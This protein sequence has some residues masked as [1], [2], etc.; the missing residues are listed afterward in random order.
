MF[1]NALAYSSAKDV[2]LLTAE[3]D[4]R[5]VAAAGCD[6]RIR[7]LWQVGVDTLPEYRNLGL[8]AFL[9]RR[10]AEEC[11][12]RGKVVFY[13]TWPANLASN[14]TALRAG[15]LPVNLELYSVRAGD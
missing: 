9:T 4:G 10:M 1:R 3:K 2:L 5:V 13:S 12:A 11:R 14:R 6:D 7:S 8:S 15:F